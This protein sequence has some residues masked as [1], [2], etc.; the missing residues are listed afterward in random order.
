M[1]GSHMINAPSHAHA[2]CTDPASRRGCHPPPAAP[3][4]SKAL[5]EA[6]SFIVHAP[7]A[8]PLVCQS[9]SHRRTSGRGCG[10]ADAAA[11]T[12]MWAI[13]A[14]YAAHRR[15]PPPPGAPMGDSRQ[16]IRYIA[17]HPGTYAQSSLGHFGAEQKLSAAHWHQPAVPSPQAA[18][19]PALAP[20]QPSN[21][22][23]SCRRRWWL[24]G[25]R[26]HR[27][28]NTGRWSERPASPQQ[29]QGAAACCPGTKA[30][31]QRLCL[32]VPTLQRHKFDRV[33]ASWG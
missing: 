2:P 15:H 22:I 19:K 33:N 30:G 28:S 32:D 27:G 3:Y 16:A 20:A 23:N 6:A 12:S 31:C 21:K 24:C 13:S 5:V 11:P 25:L 9:Q 14:A 7:R 4:K 10:G 29:P 18:G 17:R 1:T 8:S 26:L